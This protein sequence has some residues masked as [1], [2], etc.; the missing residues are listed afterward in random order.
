MEERKPIGMDAEGA[1]PLKIAVMT[2]VNQF[3]GLDGKEITWQ[4]LS[5]DG[6]IAVEPESGA[7]VY[8]EETDIMGTVRQRCQFPFF[9]VYRSGAASEY[10]KMNVTRF[11]DE[12]GAWLSREPVTLDG[13]AYRLLKYPEVEGGRKIEKIVRFNS[14]ALERNE[15]RTQDWV[16]PVTVNYTHEFEKW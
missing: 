13:V 3:P 10:Q 15:N 14:Y 4:G 16:L 9:V 11:L 5:E 8:T 1:E 12:L 2:L 6:G 7:L